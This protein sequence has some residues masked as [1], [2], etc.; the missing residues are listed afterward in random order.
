MDSATF[1][2]VAGLPPGWLWQWRNHYR[3][4]SDA[5][6]ARVRRLAGFH[7]GIRIVTYGE[8]DYPSWWRRRWTK[9]S[10]IGKRSPLEAV[11]QNPDMMD[12]LE[13]YLRA[14]MW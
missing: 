10:F 12:R 9:G 13:Q 3:A 4:P 2:K 1:E 7:D 11:L 14:Q 6:L 8:P 5:E